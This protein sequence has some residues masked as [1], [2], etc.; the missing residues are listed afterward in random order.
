MSSQPESLSTEMGEGGE[1]KVRVAFKLILKLKYAAHNKEK[2]KKISKSILIWI[3]L[4]FFLMDNLLHILYHPFQLSSL[5]SMTLTNV[6]KK[7]YMCEIWL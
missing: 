2:V 7:M 5:F 4:I 3:H 1:C 6:R